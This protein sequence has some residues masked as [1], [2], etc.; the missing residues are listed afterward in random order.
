MRV[1]TTLLVLAT[2]A[3]STFALTLSDLR[4]QVRRTLDDTSTE[5]A[6]QHWTDAELNFLINQGQREVCDTI[7]WALY[8]T[9]TAYTTAYSTW[10]ALPTDCYAIDRLVIDSAA[11]TVIPEVTLASKDK[12]DASWWSGGAG[13]PDSYFWN[14]ER[15]RIGFSPCP[16]A[17]YEYTIDYVAIPADMDDDADVPFNGVTKLKPYHHLLIHYVVWWCSK[18]KDHYQLYSAGLQRMA[19]AIKV[20]PNYIPVIG[21]KMQ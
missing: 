21:G 14:T 18:D 8:A 7:A 1:L 11:Y 2:L 12:E 4:T 16:N 15:T 10:V 5:T 19:N 13:K 17:A 20:S 3:S 9:S 6:K